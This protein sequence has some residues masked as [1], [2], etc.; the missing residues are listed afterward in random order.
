[1]ACDYCYYLD[2]DSLYP[3]LSSPRMDEETLEAVIVQH[4]DATADPVIQFS[5]HGG[6]PTIPGLDYFRRITDLQRRLIPPD[7]TVHNGIQTNGTL[8]DE[9][10]A[11]FLA[12]ESFYVGIS[13]DGPREFHDTFRRTRDGGSA[14]DETLRGLRLLQRFGVTHEILCVV[15]AANAGFPLTTYR[16]FRELGV[17]FISFLPLVEP[18]ESPYQDRSVP[19]EMWGN[20]LCEVFD[21]WKR[22]DIGRVKI[23]IFEEAMRPAF[24][25]DHTLCLFKKTCGRVPVIERNGDLYSCDHYVN[26]DFRLGNILETPLSSLLESPGQKSF[27]RAKWEA[28]PGYCRECEVL[29]SCYGECPKNRFLRTPEGEPGL[30]VLCRGYKRFFTHCRPFVNEVAE[31]WKQSAE[32]G[33][34]SSE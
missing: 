31:L 22:E 3:G 5:W 19:A 12:A 29:E 9:D 2:R 4:R 16:F 30:N 26:E 33:D 13:L 34:G 1:M 6:E 7:R 27:G 17:P 11:R 25:Q 23:Q 15:S 28:L 18:P 21:E 14:F 20:F 32:S 24:G 8:L 10:W